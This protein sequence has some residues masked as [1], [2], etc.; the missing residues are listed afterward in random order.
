MKISTGCPD[1]R[2]Y[3]VTYEED[4]GTNKGKEDA[5][6]QHIYVLSILYYFSFSR[7]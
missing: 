1:I 2:T 5:G 3:S 4:E 6:W 7:E